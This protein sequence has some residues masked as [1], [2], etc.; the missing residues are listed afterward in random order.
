VPHRFTDQRVIID[1]EKFHADPFGLALM[2]ALNVA[3]DLGMPARARV[4][5][6]PAMAADAYPVQTGP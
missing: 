5:R 6:L 1:D 2:D 4:R 3:Q